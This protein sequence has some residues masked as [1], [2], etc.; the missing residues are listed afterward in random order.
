MA[1]CDY[2]L[3]DVCGGK[4]FYDANLSYSDDAEY[5]PYRLAGEEQYPDHP[6]LAKKYGQRLGY[7]GDWVVICNGCSKTHRTQIVPL[8]AATSPTAPEPL[9]S[10][11]PNP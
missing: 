5:I 9:A 11:L 10:A 6:D 1:L 3:C 2:R 8:T 4:A 7:V